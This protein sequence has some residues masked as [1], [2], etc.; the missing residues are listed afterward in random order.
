M[1]RSIE[2][3]GPDPAQ[4]GEW[5]LP[6]HSGAPMVILVHGGFWRPIW[7]RDLEEATAI[8]LAEH[9]FAVF[10][11]EYRDYEHDWPAALLDT[12]AAIDLAFTSAPA[13][14]VDSSRR[15]LCGH[16]AGGGL[17]AWTTSRGGIPQ[18]H[19][20]ANP[21]PPIFDAITLHAPVASWVQASHDNLGDGAVDTFM[22]GPPE[23]KPQRYAASDPI[24]LTPDPASRRLLVHGDNDADV[25]LSQST[26]Y[27]HHLRSHDMAVDY[28]LRPGEGHYEILDPDSPAS[29]QRREFLIEA[30]QDSRQQHH[31]DL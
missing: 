26:A 29:V 13:H 21:S 18:G 17:V 27:A 23:V 16:S 15:A 22:G 12:V 4:V 9:G 1:Q 25:P 6:E 11:C 30:L 5:F 24:G 19:P 3:Y 14:D 7:R 8:N 2:R 10:N 28:V 31:R 20:G